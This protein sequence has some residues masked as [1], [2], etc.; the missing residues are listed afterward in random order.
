MVKNQALT[1]GTLSY[2]VIWD[3]VV[4][5]VEVL[6]EALAA[7]AVAAAEASVEDL[8][9]AASVEAVLPGDGRFV[10]SIIQYAVNS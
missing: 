1:F 6:V 8:A 10:E 2:S 9:E 3:E 4:S 7:V 5:E